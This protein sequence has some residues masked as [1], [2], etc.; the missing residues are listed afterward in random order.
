MCN[1][2]VDPEPSRARK[3]GENQTKPPEADDAGERFALQKDHDTASFHTATD[4]SSASAEAGTPFPIPADLVDHPRYRI[5]EYLGSRGM[6]M[7]YKARHLVMDRL[8]ALKII[9]PSLLDRPDMV[10]RFRREVQAAARLDHPNIVVAYDAGQAGDT[11][12]LVMEYVGGVDLD[13]LLTEHGRFPVAAACDYAR[14]AAL[15]LQHAHE[16]G[17]V[18]RDMKPHNLMLT[19]QAQIKILDFG[20]ARFVSEATPVTPLTPAATP[21]ADPGAAVGSRPRTQELFKGITYV[22]TGVGTADYGAPEEAVDAR[23]A[24]IRA[25]IYSLGCTLYRC[26]AGRVPFPVGSVAEK[27]LAHQ[28]QIPEPLTALRPEVP[29]GLAQVVERMMAKDPDQRYQTPADVA[30]ALQPFAVSARRPILVVDDNAAVRESLSE[31]LEG[32][33]YAVAA[34]ANGREALDLLRNGP[35]P[36][37][38]LLDLLMP[39][40]DGWQFLQ[41]YKQDPALASI[42][43]VIISAADES[44]AR[45]IALG[46]ADYLQKPVKPDELSSKVQGF[47]SP[48]S[49]EA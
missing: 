45:A 2:N 41:E 5:L 23:R 46:A 40:M 1:S 12:F 13:R 16:K 43:V 18:H 27:I 29:A 24:D 32:Q 6:G 20:L 31:I 17:L 19:P 10:E 22:D 28:T 26:L 11:H 3:D 48:A 30:R 33:G 47:V 25:D 38:I 42:P 35:R 15:A 21:Q 34:A 4:R 36:G 37:L 39:V 44:Q 8:V 7:V 14:Q 49:G 9:N